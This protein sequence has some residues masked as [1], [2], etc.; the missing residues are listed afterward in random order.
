MDIK[1]IFDKLIEEE[2]STKKKL[3][4]SA[5]YLFSKKGF[6]NV[7]IRELCY[8]VSV[9][10]SAFYNHYSSKDKLIESIFDYFE[11]TTE[12]VVM[13]Q[14]E[15][16]NAAS[17][18]IKSF[19]LE[20]MKKFSS[21]TSNTLYHT[22][23]Q[24][25]LSE[26]FIHPRA[27]KIAKQNFYRL[28]KGYTE[29]VL[30]MMIENGRIKQCDVKLVTAEYYYALKGMLDEYILLETWG[31]DKEEIEKRI[32]EHIE[33]FASLLDAGGGNNEV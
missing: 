7:G 26:S 2:N 27:G 9:K 1:E 32:Y 25:V 16:E 24:I 23:L 18:D 12:K 30:E 11:E 22:V 13:T 5:V 3:F 15:I 17:G 14:E 8:S 20:N 33:F 6:N 28:R 29:K 10:E 19:L 4:Y 21:Y 31:D